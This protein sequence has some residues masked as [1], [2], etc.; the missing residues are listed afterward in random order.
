VM[1]M[2]SPWQYWCSGSWVEQPQCLDGAGYLVA[3]TWSGDC[4]AGGRRAPEGGGGAEEDA[5]SALSAERDSVHGGTTAVGSD[6]MA[7]RLLA[8]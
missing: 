5:R 7:V 4:S 2:M 8:W 3:S 6:N 1:Q